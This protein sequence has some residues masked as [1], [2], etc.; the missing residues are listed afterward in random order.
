MTARALSSCLIW[1]KVFDLTALVLL[2]STAL[3]STHSKHL[4][5][6][7]ESIPQMN[8]FARAHNHADAVKR[9]DITWHA[10][11]FN[12]EPEVYDSSLFQ[13]S[14]ILARD[15]ALKLGQQAPRTMSQRGA[16][17]RST[18]HATLTLYPDVP[19]MTRGVIPLLAQQGVEAISVGVN[20]GSSPPAGS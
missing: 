17:R 11:P 1:S 10:F 16:T 19:G 18:F 4:K 8:S 9:G 6:H 20:G 14:V 7:A 2:C 12:A 13:S 3:M 5:V 15:L